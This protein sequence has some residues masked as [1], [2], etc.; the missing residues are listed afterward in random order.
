[1]VILS[2]VDVVA[3]SEI[4]IRCK[5]LYLKG[6]WFLKVKIIF[7]PETVVSPLRW[8]TVTKIPSKEIK[9]LVILPLSSFRSAFSLVHTGNSDHPYQV[10]WKYQPVGVIGAISYG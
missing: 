5:Q 6:F 8:L 3:T 1:M 2:E 9:P 7:T 10:S 4:R